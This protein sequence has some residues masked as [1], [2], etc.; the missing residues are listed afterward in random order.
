MDRRPTSLFGQPANATATAMASAPVIEGVVLDNTV[1]NQIAVATP[2]TSKSL[3]VGKSISEDQ[4]VKLGNA[5]GNTIAQISGRILELHKGS[6]QGVMGDKLNELIKSAKGMSSDN[7]KPGAIR[8]LL[9]KALNLKYDMMTRFDSAKDRVDSL[10]GELDKEKAAQIQVYHN[11]EELIKGNFLYCKALMEE[12][13]EG[14]QMLQVIS[15]EIAQYT[16]DQLTAEQAHDL[17]DARNRYDLLEKKL[18]DLESFKV[19]SMNMDPKLTAM[20]SGAQSLIN[21]FE[22][23][24]N[25]MVPAYMLYFADYLNAQAQERATAL[26]NAAIDSFDQI[27]QASGDLS[28]KNMEA[29]GHLKNRQLVSV[30]TVRKEHEKMIEGLNNLRAIEEQARQDRAR[31]IVELRD[32][33][34]KSIEA[35]SRK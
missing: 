22:M 23:I 8:G 14:K 19:L 15:D 29:I 10:V 28:A 31:T 30:E 20:K 2:T 33:E 9:N 35:F 13:E 34:Q 7:F 3:V 24:V 6:N 17:N 12:I 5:S 16:E 32:I 1:H 26:S 21:T 27:V 4:I 25:K 18:V 11:I